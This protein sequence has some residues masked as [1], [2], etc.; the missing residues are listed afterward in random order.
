MAKLNTIRD[1]IV[2]WTSGA[3]PRELTG[4]GEVAMSM[5]WNDDY[6]VEHAEELDAAW[7]DWKSR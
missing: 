7:Q 5:I 4:S 3:Q 1:E 6:L 2:F